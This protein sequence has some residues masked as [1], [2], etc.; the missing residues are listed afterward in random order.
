VA[1][2]KKFRLGPDKKKTSFRIDS[3]SRFLKR[4]GDVPD[5]L[6]EEIMSGEG[7]A[8]DHGQYRSG[9]FWWVALKML[10]LA[11]G[12]DLF[13]RYQ[14]HARC[15][16]IYFGEEDSAARVKER[17]LGLCKGLNIN[18][19]TLD[20][21]LYICSRQGLSFDVEDH[22]QWIRTQVLKLKPHL[23]IIDPLRSVTKS[24]DS[25]GSEIHDFFRFL[26]DLQNQSTTRLEQSLVAQ[27]VHHDRKNDQLIDSR[28]SSGVIADKCEVIHQL[29]QLSTTKTVTKQDAETSEPLEQTLELVFGVTLQD[30]KF[31]IPDEPSPHSSYHFGVRIRS[32]RRRV[33]STRL[34]RWRWRIVESVPTW[35][36]QEALATVSG[37]GIVDL[38][39]VLPVCT[40]EWQTVSVIARA[41]GLLPK[42]GGRKIL[43]AIRHELLRQTLRGR[44]QHNKKQRRFSMYRLTAKGA[45]DA[46]S[47]RHSSISPP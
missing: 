21:W 35:L 42:K 40:E 24:G 39:K 34:K 5:D 23:I 14:V 11:S 19:V 32:H 12:Q 28:S 31:D 38:A 20:G 26:R 25:G 8:L 47:S 17:L 1:K 33:F 27:I 41:T 13:G 6:I 4:T 7:N 37:G 9:K 46:S 22:R 18:P 2:K 36:S 43:D 10:A 3:F 16:V 44:L 45:A 29:T 30:Y 15:R